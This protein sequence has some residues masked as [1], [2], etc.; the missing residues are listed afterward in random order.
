MRILE[1]INVEITYEPF[2]TVVMGLSMEIS[3]DGIIALLGSNGAGKSTVLKAVSGLIMAERGKVTKG[4]I[5][6]FGKDITNI[7]PEVRAKMGIIHVLEGRKV[8][9][10]LTVEENLRVGITSG[11]LDLVYNYFPQL[12]ERR[13]IRAGYLSGG[14]QQMLVIGRALLTKPRLMLLDEPSLGLSPLFVGQLFKTIKRINEEEKIP[15]I[16]VEQN[17]AM[18]LEIADYGY[19]MENGKIVMDGPAEELLRN[20]DIQE[21]YL[22]MGEAGRRS[23][24]EAKAYKRRKRWL[25]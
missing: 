2:I 7:P 24:R 1:L 9:R 17:V 18:A 10:E 6:F 3:K 25:A 20:K 23:Y 4:K 15:I 11:D 19:V 12:R 8:F 22:G 14:E 13:K 5:N 21:F 16:L